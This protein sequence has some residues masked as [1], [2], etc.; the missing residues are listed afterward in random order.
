MRTLILG[1]AVTALSCVNTVSAEQLS[2]PA[3]AADSERVVLLHGLGRSKKAMLLLEYRLIKAGFEVHNIGYPSREEGPDALLQLVGEQVEACCTG[4]GRVVH[5]VAHSLGGL[6]VR[7]YLDQR[8]S[9]RLGRAVLLGTPN[10]GSRLVDRF[11]DLQLFELLAGPTAKVLGTDA[12][13]F[14]RQIG[15]PYYPIGIIAGSR[16]LNPL[17]DKLLAGESD[18]AVA[19]ENTKLEG[20]TDFLIVDTG[21]TFMRYSA[22]VAAE[23]IHFLQHGRFSRSE[24]SGSSIGSPRSDP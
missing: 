8:P 5:F 14:P 11:G 19:L 12:S 7:A 24:L 13:S 15:L 22:E 17:S 4:D 1:Y 6:I 10:Q 2:Q 23:V 3:L 16:T 9:L 21:H 20:M 18:G